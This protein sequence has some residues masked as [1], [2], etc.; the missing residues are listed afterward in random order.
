[1]GAPVKVMCGGHLHLPHQFSW[2]LLYSPNS[3]WDNKNRPSSRSLLMA[4]TSGARDVL[5]RQAKQGSFTGEGETGKKFN[6]SPQ[7]APA[8]TT[9]TARVAR[10]PC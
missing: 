1:M 5:V 4:V 7:T 10:A 6:I 3:Q 8:V 9:P 2:F